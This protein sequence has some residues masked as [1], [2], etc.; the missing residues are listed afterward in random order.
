MTKKNIGIIVGS[1]RK[2]SFSRSIANALIE[3]APEP[4]ATH[5]VE[6]GNLPLY[7]QDM[8]DE[9]NTPESYPQFRK[10]I[11]A[12]DGVLFVTPEYNRSMPAV[13][14]NALDVASRPYGQNQWNGKPG[15]IVSVSMFPPFFAPLHSCR[16]SLLRTES[17]VLFRSLRTGLLYRFSRGCQRA[18]P[19]FRS[20]TPNGKRLFNRTFSAHT[21][22][23]FL[24][25]FF[26]NIHNTVKYLPIIY[27]R[28]RFP[29]YNVL[30]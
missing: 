14:K 10:E 28:S 4:L 16:G 13:L 6:I 7:N 12:L 24:R 3:L 20:Q 29:F 11:A 27:Y 17:P 30:L 5:I 8:D 26:R 1:L 25:N 23:R 15:A 19:V 18:G 21:N 22:L 9:G 2:G